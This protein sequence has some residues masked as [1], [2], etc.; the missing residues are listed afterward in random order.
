MFKEK[1]MNQNLLDI[2]KTKYRYL[3]DNIDLSKEQPILK[4]CIP[5]PKGEEKLTDEFYNRDYPDVTISNYKF[6]KMIDKVAN[7]L[8]AYGIKAGDVVTVCQTNTPEIMYMDYALN[9]IGACAN[10]IY[11]NI[12]AEEM[13]YYIE[14]LNSK[15]LFILDDNDIKQNVEKATENSDIKIIS[16]SVIESFPL[17]FKMVANKKNSVKSK[18]LK[19]EIKWVEFLKLGKNIN[20]NENEYISNSVCSYMHTSGTSSVPKAVMISNENLNAIPFNYEYEN[21]KWCNGYLAVQTI[22]QFVAY[23]ETTNHLFLCN[24][25]CVVLIPEMNPKNYYD[26]MNKYHP[27]YSFATPSHARE[28]LKRNVDMTDLLYIC[29]GGDGFDDVEL[30]LNEYLRKN[31][32]KNPAYQGFGSTEMSATAGISNIEKYHKVG[33]IGMPLGKTKAMILEP[34]TFNVITTP[35]TEGELCLTGPGMTLGYAGNSK[36][37][38]D[39]V[40]VKHP[41][42]TTW[43]HMGDLVSF[44]KDGFYYYHGR[45]KNVIVRKSFKFA[46]K[47]IV[48]AIMF[49]PNVKQCIVFGKYDAEE[50]QVPSAHIVLKDNSNVQASVD[51]IVELVNANV[52]EFHRP[53]VYKIK[54]SIVTTRNNKININALKIEDIATIIDGVN[55]AEISLSADNDYDYDLKIYINC[56][57]DEQKAIDFIEQTS[58]N[59]KVLNGKIKYIF[60]QEKGKSYYRYEK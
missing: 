30:L 6:V 12:T 13:K 49:C 60:I 29:F 40:Y 24:N 5:V 25:V 46:P 26:L 57:V 32:S 31:N 16:S 1:N 37:D 7:S 45:I 58:K 50:G 38:N 56:A 11:P 2:N 20:A 9:K 33:S 35:N 51:E 47:E 14:E 18:K 42:G 53:V 48:D 34:G 52:Q 54:D 22:P 15:C 28:L 44:D 27:Q 39:S 3:M 59:E 10:Y 8:V 23:G 21:V 41:D 17:L 36:E 19:N 4:Y 43:V 55:D